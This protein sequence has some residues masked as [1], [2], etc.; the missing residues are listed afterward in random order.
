M[1][2]FPLAPH[3]AG[4]VQLILNGDGR[5]VFASTS[6]AATLG[7]GVDATT[8]ERFED[9]LHPQDVAEFQRAWAAVSDVAEATEATELRVLHDDGTWRTCE[10]L[11]R[12]RTDSW[13]LAGV[14]VVLHDVTEQRRAEKTL[15]Q[16]QAR[17]RALAGDLSEVILTVDDVLCV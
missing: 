4:E 3:F 10:A 14:V 12:D 8:G 16:A 15:E 6:I 17:L 1:S 9:L 5:I 2:S 7:R 13:A 11:V